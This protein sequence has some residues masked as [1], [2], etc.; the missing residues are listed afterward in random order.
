MADSIKT[1][2]N[3]QDDGEFELESPTFDGLDGVDAELPG[4]DTWEGLFAADQPTDSSAD[5]EFI[6]PDS[7]GFDSAFPAKE[8]ISTLARPY[9]PRFTEVTE[10][11]NY[12]ADQSIVREAE[13]A[14]EQSRNRSASRADGTAAGGKTGA[15][16][17]GKG[18]IVVERVDPAQTTDNIPS[19]RIDPIAEIES[20]VPEAVVVNIN[21]GGNTKKSTINVFKFPETRDGE[22]APAVDDE[23]LERREISGLTGHRWDAEE[24]EQE[25]ADEVEEASVEP[26]ADD[27]P[28]VAAAEENEESAYE[29]E[30]P[31]DYNYMPLG[32]EANESARAASDNSEYT[33]PAKHETFKD[34]F[35]DSLMS[36]RIRLIVAVLLG[37]ATAVFELFPSQII[38]YFGLG[39]APNA[40]AFIDCALIVALLL[41]SLPEIA[42]LFRALFPARR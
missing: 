23:E 40:A 2:V 42:P 24:G 6:I 20:A 31:A 26:T 9:V 5:D 3:D 1:N 38:A 21:G 37:L 30:T 8:Y 17:S 29:Q 28:I 19:G 16:A 41:I 35:L 14:A 32:Y 34:R 33:S 11:R 10:N 13:R 7:A 36:I 4:E 22:D 12:F 25:A 27:E 15:V 39:L 18:G